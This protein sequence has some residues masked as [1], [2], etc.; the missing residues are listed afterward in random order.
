MRET[1]RQKFVRLANARVPKA[2]KAI[3]LVGNLSNR[4]NYAYHP[5][6]AKKLVDALE[7]EIR[8]LK[9]RF[10]AKI[11]SDEQLFKLEA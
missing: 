2:I 5:H 4:S 11:E 7:K 10:E 8:A 3:R 9:L 1:D 6:E